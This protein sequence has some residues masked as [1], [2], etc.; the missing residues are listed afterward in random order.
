[1]TDMISR[2]ILAPAAV[3][4][5]WTLLVLLWMA[6][7]RF[8]A[9]KAANI[10]LAEAKPGRRGQHLEGVLPD[11]IMWPAHNY[12]HLVEQ[13]TIFYAVV[14]ILALLGQG[15]GLNLSLAWAYVGVRILHSLWQIGVNTIPVR[16]GLFLLSTTLLL[17]LA[18]NALRAAL[19]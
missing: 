4:V 13:P 7:T 15:T 6:F 14:V 2:E 5:F 1:M 9:F 18:I 16:F 12:A 8:S 19:A 17:I 3:L 11:K 10:N